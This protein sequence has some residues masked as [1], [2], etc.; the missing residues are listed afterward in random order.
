MVFLKPYFWYLI[1][2]LGILGKFARP[3]RLWFFKKNFYG[4]KSPF[5]G[6]TGALCFGLQL[7]LSVDFKARVDSSLPTLCS[8]LHVMILLRVN[9]EF[10]GLDLSQFYTLVRWGYHWSDHQCHF[11]DNWQGQG[12]N[13]GTRSPKTCRRSTD[14]AI[15]AG[16]AR[17]CFKKIDWMYWSK[18]KAPV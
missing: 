7:T 4:D 6:A 13:P 14:W 16:L 8:H 2:I 18:V 17:L 10:P 3:V 15:P 11:L 1:W 5:C 9:S 12:S